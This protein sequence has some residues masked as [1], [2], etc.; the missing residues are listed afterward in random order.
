LHSGHPMCVQLNYDGTTL[1]MTIKD[2]I[3]AKSFSVSWAINIAQT[4]GSSSA[5]VG[6][7]ASTGG[8]T[9]VQEVLNWTY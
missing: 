2:T 8:A 7:T 5:Y 1:R 6:F 4:V 3:T 9:A